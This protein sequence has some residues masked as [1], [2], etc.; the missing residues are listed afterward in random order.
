MRRELKVPSGGVEVSE[1]LIGDD[2]EVTLALERVRAYAQDHD[3][4]WFAGASR[5]R[6][7]NG[8]EHKSMIV[9]RVPNNEFDARVR[10]F[11]GDGITVVLQDAPHSESELVD[12]L[13]Q[14]TALIGPHAIEGSIWSIR[15][16]GS[17][18]TV[19]LPEDV[20]TW[21][22]VMDEHFPGYVRVAYG[23][24]FPA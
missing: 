24:A 5:L 1:P 8:D 22:R 18:I 2:P 21:Q 10:A 3:R 20:S 16:D 19:R 14:A 13:H 9:W 23:Q 11:A 17:G 7:A 15:P 4:E 12:V 6:D